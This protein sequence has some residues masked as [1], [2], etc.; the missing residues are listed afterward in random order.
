MQ[1]KQLS[2]AW[3]VVDWRVFQ[4][5]LKVRLTRPGRRLVS[6]YKALGA[7]FGV[8]DA[9]LWNICLDLPPKIKT[10][11][12]SSRTFSA[13]STFLWLP[14]RNSAES[15]T[16]KETTGNPLRRLSLLSSRSYIYIYIKFKMS[17]Y[18][19]ST[20]FTTKSIMFI[21]VVLKKTV[22][23]T[24]KARSHWSKF[25]SYIYSNCSFFLVIIKV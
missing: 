3:P 5:C 4:N 14:Y 21:M 9:T 19:F 12:D 16:D 22:H 8:I 10:S 24:K 20:H 7:D 17:K 18:K 23:A 13:L 25:L 6:S 15:P 2:N 1:C 11:P